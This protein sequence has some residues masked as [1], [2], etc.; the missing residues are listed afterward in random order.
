MPPAGACT[1]IG[2]NLLGDWVMQKD[3][4]T[5]RIRF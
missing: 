4:L 3:A 5:R 1:M 2:S